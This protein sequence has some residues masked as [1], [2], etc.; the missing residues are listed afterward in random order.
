MRCREHHVIG[1][2]H[3]PHG[4]ELVSL[5]EAESYHAALAAAGV[6][7][8]AGTF[9]HALLGREQEIA[10]LGKFAHRKGVGNPLVL[11]QRQQVGNMHTFGGTAA[12][13]H[14]M[15]LKL[16]H[17]PLVGEEQQILMI[18][19]GEELLYEVVLGRMQPGYPLAASLLLLVIGQRGTLDV[20][21]AGQG[22]D[23]ILIGNEVFNVDTG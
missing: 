17:A 16:M 19:G 11:F 1:I 6:Q 15:H 13:R 22:D 18:G 23:H 9:D 14:L 12:F 5:L 4:D 2:R 20:A 7:R 21:A 10:V 8:G 3:F